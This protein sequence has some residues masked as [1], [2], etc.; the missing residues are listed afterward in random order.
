[1][2]DFNSAE[3]RT[4]RDNIKSW[5]VY[6]PEHESYGC[7]ICRRRDIENVPNSFAL[8]KGTAV[9]NTRSS[10]LRKISLHSRK[11]S[12][13]QSVEQEK[14]R[15]KSRISKTIQELQMK[16]IVCSKNYATAMRLLDVYSSVKANIPF[17]RFPDIMQWLDGRN[18]AH[19]AHH[20]ERTSVSRM[21]S[22][23]S[24][25]MNKIL[26][27]QLKN[28]RPKL[29]CNPSSRCTEEEQVQDR[30]NQKLGTIP[31]SLLIDSLTDSSGNHVFVV[32]IQTLENDRVVVYYYKL[33]QVGFDETAE[34]YRDLITK[35]WNKDGIYDVVTQALVGIASDSASVFVGRGRKSNRQETFPVA[36]GEEGNSQVDDDGGLILK[37]QRQMRKRVLV[38]KCLPHRLNSAIRK[39][40]SNIPYM[41]TIEERLKT[42]HNFF[43][44]QM[45]KTGAHLQQ[46]AKA[47]EETLYSYTYTFKTRWIA[48][49]RK[50]VDKVCKSYSLLLIDLEDIS[51]SDDKSLQKHKATAAGIL[52]IYRGKLNA[53][54]LHFLSDMLAVLDIASRSLQESGAS[55]IGKSIII[56]KLTMGLEKLKTEN[57]VAV[58]SF[59]TNVRCYR[60]QHSLSYV[61]DSNKN[62][63]CT[64]EIYEYA[65]RVDY[66][67]PKR[68]D[69]ITS[70]L[71]DWSDY[72]TNARFSRLR[73]ELINALL[74]VIDSYLPLDEVKVY[75]VFLPHELPRARLTIN[76]GTYGNSEISTLANEYELDITKTLEQWQQLL[77]I[78]AASALVHQNPEDKYVYNL[79]RKPH[80]FWQRV[81]RLEKVRSAKLD[82]IIY[83]IRVALVMPGS[84][85]DPERL[86]SELKYHRGDRRTRLTTKKID[87]ILRLYWNGPPISTFNPFRYVDSWF[88]ERH[89]ATDGSYNLYKRKKGDAKKIGNA[90]R[91]RMDCPDDRTEQVTSMP[92]IDIEDED[93][94]PDQNSEDSA[95]WLNSQNDM[96]G[97]AKSA[98]F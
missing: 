42:L 9:L 98:L 26:L 32:L 76:A 52:K 5:F 54:T 97:P 23:L 61:Q 1:M 3:Y 87:Q 41:D 44:N 29:K 69:V 86:F 78:A 28:N 7:T 31:M 82:H 94:E 16:S 34:G 58:T 18:I 90:K 91:G 24:N 49:E 64:P 92:D 62:S 36:E 20:R 12:H 79:S 50:A 40:F 84:T 56:Q 66:R 81:L 43:N 70:L 11:S 65:Y 85:A 27:D 15:L 55:L 53:L 95:Y 39:A 68:P 22:H 57:G 37:L 14:L 88:L 4:T 2:P 71:D 6:F 60:S 75:D 46:L 48:S 74:D 67:H 35:Q 77:R 21:V 38:F 33:L 13:L 51:V 45:H 80:M 59:L 93:D 73:E 83:L 30:L 25:E 8:E 72:N 47:L 17:D 89:Y 19:G 96:L 63:R 10:N